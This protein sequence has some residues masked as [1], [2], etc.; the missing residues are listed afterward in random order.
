MGTRNLTMVQFNNEIKVA[1]YGQWDGYPSGQ[2]ATILMF[3]SNGANLEKLKLKLEKVRF[4]K[5]E[6]EIE[7]FNKK[8][9]EKD[10]HAHWL[11]DNYNHRDICG[12]ILEKIVES[13]EEEIILEN[14]YNF[15]YDGLFCEWA[16]CVNLDTNKLE[17]YCGCSKRP[18]GKKQRF[19]KENQKPDEYGYHAIR[20]IKQFDLN[21]LPS[22]E[23]FVEQLE[24]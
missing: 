3:C 2:G 23:E 15:G 11:Y 9:A 14:D 6:K 20:M 8:L 18:L 13:E 10:A 1:Q 24:R 4:F 7:Q 21:N 12:K 5:E 16:Y 17:V 19:Y 22:L